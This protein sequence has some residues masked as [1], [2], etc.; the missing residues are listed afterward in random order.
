MQ[1]RTQALMEKI[2]IKELFEV[3]HGKLQGSTVLATN[4]KENLTVSQ[5]LKS[6]AYLI[7]FIKDN[8]DVDKYQ[9]SITI[10]FLKSVQLVL[11]NG[12][13][14]K[15]TK[16]DANII[17]DVIHEIADIHAKSENEKKLNE[18]IAVSLNCLIEILK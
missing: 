10:I 7:K 13:A 8:F 18:Q 15:P 4:G 5:M 17:I 3:P 9:Y 11:N 16:E 14:E 1:K 2:G 6:A 12:N